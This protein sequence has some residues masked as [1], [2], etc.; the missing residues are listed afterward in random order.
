[1]LEILALAAFAGLLLY[2][3]YTDITSLTIPNWISIAL[4][5]IF[6]VVAPFAGLT[7]TDMAVHLL[8]G[9]GVLGVGF[10]LF[11]ANVFGGGDAKLLAA[12]A[13][14]TG[15]IAIIPLL[16]WTAMA[17]GALALAMLMARKV[18]APVD[19]W[20]PF[21]NRLLT[22]QTGVPYGVAIMIGGL[23]ATPALPIAARALTLL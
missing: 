3:A 17:G 23:I 13:V 8:F 7:L 5:A 12:A 9:L 10:L 21:V 4:T 1:M 14:W 6:I 16:T 19:G 22:P 11:Q 18:A 20:P 2:A 15:S